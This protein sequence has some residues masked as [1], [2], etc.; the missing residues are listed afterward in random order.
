MNPASIANRRADFR[1]AVRPGPKKILVVDQN[2]VDLRGIGAELRNEG[3]EVIAARSGAEAL[4]LLSAQLVD[5]I[6]LGMQSPVESVFETCKRIKSTAEWRG[7]PLILRAP[8]EMQQAMVDGINAGADDCIFKSSDLA[9]LRAR[10]R[11]QLRRK[12]FEDEDREIRERF[13]QKEMEAAAANSAYELAETR[14]AG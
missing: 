14:C 1:N 5:C 7:T 6:L 13:L 2:D 4:E 8:A 12:Q 11:A 9:V 3:C 10:V